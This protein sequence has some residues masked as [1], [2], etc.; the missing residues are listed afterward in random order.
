MAVL[1]DF[2]TH[3]YFSDDSTAST[4]SMLRGAVDCGLKEL[5]ITEHLDYEFGISPRKP[6]G[7]IIPDVDA[8]R[9]ELFSL[10]SHS[11]IN[12]RFGIEI[13]M[14]PHLTKENTDFAKKYD[15]DFIIGSIHTVGKMDPI[16][17]LTNRLV[18]V[19]EM[20]LKYFEELL[21]CYKDY[22]EFDVAGHID[23]IIRYGENADRNFSYGKYAELFDSM[24]DVLVRK[25]KGVEIN[26]AAIRA[27]LRE[28]HP[29]TEFLSRYRK[30]GGEIVTV[31]SDAHRPCDIGSGFYR[32]EE[33]LKTCG[34]DYYCTFKNRKPEFHTI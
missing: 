16:Y 31:G 3:S 33:L 30:M 26:T 15:F 19:E 32:A 4:E 28:L 14:Q 34:F 5:C 10:K 7:N 24:I 23:Y 27:N 8:Y 20:Y 12:L 1:A 17:T 21:Y 9:K 6:S 18:D 11:E 2:H 25:G 13:G 22:D 29:C